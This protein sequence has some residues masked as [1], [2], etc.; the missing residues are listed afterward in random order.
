MVS[1]SYTKDFASQSQQRNASQVGIIAQQAQQVS[2]SLVSQRAQQIGDQTVHDFC[3]LDQTRLLMHALAAIQSLQQQV[4]TL[5]QQV[6][7]L[8]SKLAH[9]LVL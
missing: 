8:Q 7:T 9:F 4:Q 5:Q 3:V 2:A 6:Q 1:Y